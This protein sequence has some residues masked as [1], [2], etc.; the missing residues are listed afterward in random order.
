MNDGAKLL[1]NENEA[2]D[3][4]SMSTH[5]LRRDR[6]SERS[7]GIP[8]IRIGAAIRYR[9]VDLELWIAEQTKKSSPTV[10][11][12]QTPKGLSSTDKRGRGRPRKALQTAVRL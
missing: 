5:F 1:L 3:L 11:S 9:R 6:I 8:F 2:A 12:H 7:V 4:L 10:I